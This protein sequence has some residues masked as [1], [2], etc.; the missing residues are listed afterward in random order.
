M[1]EGGTRTHRMTFEEKNVHPLPECGRHNF[2]C[3]ASRLG[4]LWYR[5]TRFTSD[6]TLLFAC[7]SVIM[8]VGG[9]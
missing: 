6:H 2:V 7:G 3:K 1:V 4:L 8:D 9:G 5:L